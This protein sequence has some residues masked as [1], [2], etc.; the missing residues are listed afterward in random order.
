MPLEAPDCQAPVNPV[1]WTQWEKPGRLAGPWL[2][3]A[4]RERWQAGRGCGRRG[5]RRPVLPP[6]ELGLW[7]KGARTTENTDSHDGCVPCCAG[8]PRARETETRTELIFSRLVMTGSPRP[9]QPRC[10]L[11]QP[12]VPEPGH[13]W[14]CTPHCRAP[15]VSPCPR[16]ASGSEQALP[17]APS[18]SPTHPPRRCPSSCREN[19]SPCGPRWHLHLCWAKQGVEGGSFLQSSPSVGQAVSNLPAQRKS[20]EPCAGSG[21]PAVTRCPSQMTA[22][23]WAS[24]C[25]P[26]SAP[27]QLPFTAKVS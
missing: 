26:A 5:P 23:S 19:S 16:W 21:E 9:G 2:E 3:K 22:G 8:G 20:T 12:R 14:L 6:C 10:I 25:A 27:P 11:V 15:G 13:R 24:P 4:D 7:V 1:G 17:P 18:C